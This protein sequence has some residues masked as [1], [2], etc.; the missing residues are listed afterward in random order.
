VSWPLAGFGAISGDCDQ[1]D[2]ELTEAA[3]SFFVNH[4]DFGAD[5][6]DA[7]D[8]ELLTE[9]GQIVMTTPNAGGS[10]VPSEAFAFELLAR[11]EGATLL[12]TETE[13][14]YDV[15]GKITDLLVQIDGLKVG[16]SVTRAVG[17]PK[18][19]PYTEAQADA[20]LD[21]KLGDILVSSANVSDEDRW[22]KQILHVIAYD[23]P[24]VASLQ[25][26]WQ[27]LPEATRADTIVIVTVSDGDDAFL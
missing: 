8:L 13:V 14:S 24:H 5:P 17:Y 3:P 18:D 11:C 20:I 15:E 26:A 16:V 23:S 27:A 2:T 25:A 12:K 10:S 6:Y 7:A 19:A 1:L 4:I 9:G 22:V 21:K